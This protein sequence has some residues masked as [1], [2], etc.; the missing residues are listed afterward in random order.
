MWLLADGAAK[1][2]ERLVWEAAA[3]TPAG[4]LGGPGF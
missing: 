2:L 3:P 1:S 4:Q